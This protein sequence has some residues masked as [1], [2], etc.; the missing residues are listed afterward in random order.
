RVYPNDRFVKRPSEKFEAK[1][2]QSKITNYAKQS[3]F[4][5]RSETNV[6]IVLVRDYENEYNWT[7]GEI[8]PKQTQSRKVIHG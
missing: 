8:K 2:G 3:Q 1:A 6:T 4:A 7:L 5:K